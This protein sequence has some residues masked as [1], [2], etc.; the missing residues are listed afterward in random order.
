MEEASND[1][2]IAPN[3][4]FGSQKARDKKDPIILARRQMEWE[5]EVS[6]K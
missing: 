5:Q 4:T 6:H 3:D 1:D 2:D